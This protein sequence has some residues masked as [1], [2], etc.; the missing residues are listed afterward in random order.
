MK[1]TGVSA[2]V[3]A[4]G[5]SM[6]AAQSDLPTVSTELADDVIDVGETTTAT[7]VL[8]NTPEDEIGSVVEIDV[9]TDVAKL[10]DIEVGE[11]VPNQ[12]EDNYLEEIEETGGA[13]VR[14][15]SW[16]PGEPIADAD[17][18]MMTVTLEGEAEGATEIELVDFLLT[19]S[20]GEINEANYEAPTLTVGDDDTGGEPPAMPT[21][22]EV[23][24]ENETSIELAWSPVSDAVEYAVSVDGE[25]EKTTTATAT[26]VHGLESETTY[27]IG[28]S[29]V[30]EDGNASDP[31]T[32]EAMTVPGSEPETP[33][34]TV[35]LADAAI[36]PNETTTVELG[37][38]EAPNGLAGFNFNTSVD[39]DVATIVDAELG[40]TFSDALFTTVEVSDETA[41]I[42]A[43]KEIE[44]DSPE[45]TDL[46]LGTVEIEG[47]DDGETVI[48]V[49]EPEAETRRTVDIDGTPV[50]P[51][52]ESATLTVGDGEPEPQP[53]SVPE[54]LTVVEVDETSVEVAWSTDPNAVE[55]V[56]Y[57]DGQHETTTTATSATITGLEP[58]TAYVIGVSAVGETDEETDTVTVDVTT[59]EDD[60]TDPEPDP[61]PEYPEWDPDE[62]YQEGDRVSWDG[63]NWEANWTNQGEEPEYDEWG[64]W[65]PV[66]GEIPLEPGEIHA[67]IDPSTTSAE[68]GERIEFTAVDTT[69]QGNWIESL[70]WDFDDGTTASGWWNAHSYDSSGEYT[71][72]LTAADQRGRETTHEVT[73]SVS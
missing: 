55:Y 29:A 53:P 60:E 32:V 27:E 37:L 68:V 14:V 25:Q 36:D 59:D 6:A 17:Y 48:D 45:A 24:S 38:T 71:V 11:Y 56:V 8:E 64:A 62:L 23:V 13:S 63:E 72:T 18:E 30:D 3:L 66:D 4:F 9:D 61:D 28:V 44:P 47:V 49:T 54:D 57:R 50:A 2:G 70:E 26:T 67:E 1:A 39:T 73:I 41:V 35:E 52:I 15:Q 42:E 34:V 46:D 58:D 65:E 7:I 16:E 22:L 20:E 19:D 43:V 31:A 69:S 40:E 21:G 10:T 51:D 12:L 5:T 33:T